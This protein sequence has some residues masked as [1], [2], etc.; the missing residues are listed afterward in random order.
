MNSYTSNT[1]S[2]ASIP[3]TSKDTVNRNDNNTNTTASLNID[4]LVDQ[5][6]SKNIQNNRD[7][8]RNIDNYINESQQNEFNDNN[9]D[10]FDNNEQYNHDLNEVEDVI[11]GANE[12]IEK[13]ASFQINFQDDIGFDKDKMEKKRAM[14]FKKMEDRKKHMAE[15]E[16]SYPEIIDQNI[17]IIN[18]KKNNKRSDSNQF[19]P[20]PNN[21]NRNSRD[22]SQNHHHNK[23]FKNLNDEND[24]KQT[25]TPT[26]HQMHYNHSSDIH[27]NISVQLSNQNS[28]SIQRSSIDRRSSSPMITPNMNSNKGLNR[29]RSVVNTNNLSSNQKEVGVRVKDNDEMASKKIKSSKTKDR[30]EYLNEIHMKNNKYN[31]MKPKQD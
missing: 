13:P 4:E 18:T 21:I 23:Y 15:K 16:R 27:N 30:Q 1:R 31:Q 22:N 28:H 29:N 19:D 12:E 5:F 2:N 9:H 6:E 3:S 17:S 25:T 7:N 11:S 10:E 14:L 26:Q 8:V 20:I 24:Y